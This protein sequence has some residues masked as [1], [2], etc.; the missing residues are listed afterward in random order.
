MLHNTLAAMLAETDA[1]RDAAL[2]REYLRHAVSREMFCQR[3]GRVLDVSTAVLVTVVHGQSRR[4]VILDG[5]AFDEVA[6]GLRSRAAT[7][8][9]SLEILDGRTL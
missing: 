8:G 4:A 7:L 1:E 6:E 5:A 2:N 9:A 3:T